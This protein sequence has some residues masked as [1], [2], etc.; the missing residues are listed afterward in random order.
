MAHAIAT[1]KNVSIAVVD[2]ELEK[3]HPDLK[4]RLIK[5]V[6]FVDGG[7][8]T[9][10][11]DQHGT[12]VAGVIGARA[13]DGVGIYGIAPDAE[14][15][16]FK[17]CWYADESENGA[18]CSSWSLAKAID[19]AILQGVKVINLSLAGPEDMLLAKLLKTAHER[20]ITVVAAALE[21][22]EHPGFPANLSSVI[23]VISADPKGNA[24]AP[25]WINELP[26]V[27]VAPG[28]EILEHCA[29][30]IL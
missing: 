21:K 8:L 4:G 10:S 18:L 14:I 5:T 19:A 22:G 1:G 28:V 13:N 16:A 2:T 23:P 20:G 6:N 7:D 3:D 12:A 27:A 15:S 29:E 25:T 17:A 26:D 30:R 9:F 11:R 24:K